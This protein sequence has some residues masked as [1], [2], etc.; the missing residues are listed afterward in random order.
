M[1][2]AAALPTA[3]E[4]L[5]YDREHEGKH[6][7][8]FGQIVAMAGATRAHNTIGANALAWLHRVG[9]PMG[10]RPYGPDQRVRL[11]LGNYNYPDVS[12][13]CDP[14]F[15]DD[16]PDSLINPLL[17]VE[18][19]SPSTAAH[20]RGEKL[21]TYTQMNSLRAYWILEQE[22]PEA[23]LYERREGL[24]TF[25]TVLGLGGAIDSPLFDEPLGMAD[26]YDG[27]ELDE[28]RRYPPG[29]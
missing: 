7:L 24:W 9:R 1:S 22:R 18:V 12:F 25:R 3:A 4:Y 11:P 5:T 10:C 6:A 14:E 16:R 15:S 17:I 28:G 21:T 27:V 23:T 2:A 29:A 13:A 8:W 19:T 20:D 26:L